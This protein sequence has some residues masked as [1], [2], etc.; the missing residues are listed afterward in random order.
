VSRLIGPSESWDSGIARPVW[1]GVISFGLVAVPVAVYPATREHDVSFHQF[2]K[3]TSDRIRYQRVN[4]RTGKDGDY[5]DIVKGA[6][7]G[8]GKCVLLDPDEL[9]AIAPGATPAACIFT[10]LSISARSIGCITV[11]DGELHFDPYGVKLTGRFVLIR[12]THVDAAGK[13]EW[14]LLHKRDDH[15]VDGWQTEDHPGR[16]DRPHQRRR[17]G[18]QAPTRRRA[19]VTEV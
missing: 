18:W 1:T 16:S 6:D 2:Q 8:D 14:L 13:Q 10:R 9:D 15:A 5:A 19:G 7:V 3:G 4:E 17:P 11:H 12:R